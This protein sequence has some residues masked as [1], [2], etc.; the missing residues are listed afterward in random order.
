MFTSSGSVSV[1]SQGMQGTRE[2]PDAHTAALSEPDLEHEAGTKSLVRPLPCWLPAQPLLPARPLLPFPR[3]HRHQKPSHPT[4]VTQ[5]PHS[6]NNSSIIPV[7]LPKCHG[8]VESLD[9]I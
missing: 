7:N 2:A 4:L 5:E 9:G 1:S 6:Q 3:P 8:G